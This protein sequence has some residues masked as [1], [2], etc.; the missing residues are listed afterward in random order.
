M[1]R[2]ILGHRLATP[3]EIRAATPRS[4]L[5]SWRAV[6]KDR[7]EDTAYVTGWKLIQ[8]KLGAHI[9]ESGNEF[10]CFKNNTTLSNSFRMLINGKTSSWDSTVMPI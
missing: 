10:L 7:N 5:K 3:D 6:W 1:I 2:C 8:E 9:D 4:V